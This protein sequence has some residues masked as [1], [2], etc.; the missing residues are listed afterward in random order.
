[1]G[2][3]TG[4]PHMVL[5][6]FK[7]TDWRFST[8]VSSISFSPGP[9]L[10]PTGTLASSSL[11]RSSISS[12]APQV[13]QILT[14][15]RDTDRTR[16]LESL[17]TLLT[18]PK[19]RLHV[20]VAAAQWLASVS[21]PILDELSVIQQLDHFAF[22][23]RQPKQSIFSLRRALRR[24]GR[25]GN[26]YPPLV[27][28]AL[29]VTDAWFDLLYS[30]G[31][32]SSMLRTPSLQ[33]QSTLL[34]WLNGIVQKFPEPI[35][36]LLR[37]W[38]E[39]EPARKAQLFGWFCRL[40]SLPDDSAIAILMRDLIQAPPDNHFPEG[41]PISVLPLLPGLCEKHPTI[42]SDILSAILDQYFVRHPGGHPFRFAPNEP[43]SSPDLAKIAQQSPASFLDGMIPALLES[44]RRSTADNGAA[45]NPR[46]LQDATRRGCSS[47][48]LAV[49]RCV[50][51]ARTGDSTRSRS[52]PRRIGSDAP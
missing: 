9:L 6:L 28:R 27:R 17:E 32:L 31:E 34:W 12:A 33:R 2:Q 11:H 50:A 21:D 40:R 42:V 4:W 22:D 52:S 37:E 5:S 44:V 3:K 16:Y 8:R 15:M 29:F 36:A 24:L 20:Q 47:L 38:W 45:P 41:D 49:P 46:S 30:A 26:P 35:A 25:R 39:H 14:L 51:F 1:M 13:R 10:L 7:T 19:I 18:N 48:V 43:L 23:C